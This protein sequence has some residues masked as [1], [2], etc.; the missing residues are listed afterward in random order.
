LKGLSQSGHWPSGNPRFYLRVDGKRHP[1][2]D[3]PKGHKGFLAAYVAATSG[4]PIP[5][6]RPAGGT[7]GAVI[8]AYLGSAGYQ[9]KAP[10]TRAYLRR[11]LDA[12]RK[13]WGD[14]R[15]SDL[16]AKHILADLAKLQ[17]HPANNR[18][19]AWKAIC[20]WAFQEGAMM[21]TDPA[22]QIRKRAYPKSDGFAA[23]TRDDVAKFRAF[24]PHDTQQRLAFELLHRTGAAMVDA[25]QIGPGHVKAGWLRY[26]RQKSHSM[27]VCPMD[28]SAPA[29]FEHDDH[30]AA[31]L[32]CH[33]RHLV[34]LTTADGA[35][36]SHKAAS[37]WFAGACR[38]AG[39]TGLSAHGLRKHRAAVWAENGATA[40]QRMAILG[41]ETAS[42][43]AHYAKSASLQRTIEGAQI[44][45]SPPVG[46]EK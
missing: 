38:K 14:A 19:R 26:S 40:E 13:T 33:P 31:C 34:Y 24:W 39:L 44:S 22:A 36:R 17:P 8:A 6:Q 9:N 29:W 1:M 28:A 15:A 32:S 37:S 41:H 10:S 27:A 42:Q 2:P 5:P 35:P 7:I 20:R 45:N 23:W 18:L 11:G 30:L 46:L 43:A 12:I 3:L 4:A 25:C 21:A 16:A